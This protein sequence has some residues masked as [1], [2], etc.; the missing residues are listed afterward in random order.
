MRRGGA[1]VNSAAA[2]RARASI[3]RRGE[4]VSVR[5]MSTTLPQTVTFRADVRAVVAGY[6]PSELVNGITVGSRKVILSRLDLDAAGFP[7]LAKGDRIY[8]GATFGT[9]TT[10]QTIDPDHREYQGCLDISVSGA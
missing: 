10:I 8:L 3:G 1:A 6:A 9:T 4:L 5:R 7:T 2:S